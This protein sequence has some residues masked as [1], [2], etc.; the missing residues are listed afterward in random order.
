MGA[1]LVLVDTNVILEAHRTG[2]WRA[3]R[4]G[5][6]LETVEDCVIETQTG[7]QNRRPEQR[8]EEAALRGDFRAIHEVG[9]I[10]R[11]NAV[12]SHPSIAFLD[13]GEQ[14]LWCHALTRTDVWV[15]CGPD[16]A[17]LRLG[18]ALGLGGRLVALETLLDEVG[19]RPV[20]ALRRNYTI[21]WHRETL[22]SLS[23]ETK[24]V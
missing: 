22:A 10:D 11:A 19:H 17:S 3:L 6:R 4:G 14:A 9:A 23:T 18:L 16:K 1:R 20:I 21:A 8:I 24:R 2:S 15:L 5:H 7:A 12:L 13:A